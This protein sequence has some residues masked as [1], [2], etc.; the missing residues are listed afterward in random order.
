VLIIF[1]CLKKC[2]RERRRGK[3]LRRLSQSW[4]WS[5]TRQ[6][7]VNSHSRDGLKL[8]LFLRASLEQVGPWLKLNTCV[9][10]RLSAVSQMP[11]FIG[12]KRPKRGVKGQKT[13][14]NTQI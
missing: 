3:A 6:T 14:K 12:Q 1:D 11:P 10:L 2:A 9:C 13:P 8:L 7:V 5:H 4:G